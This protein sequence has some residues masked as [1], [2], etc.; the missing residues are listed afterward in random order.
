MPAQH[1]NVDQSDP[2]SRIHTE[3][4][5]RL[6]EY[7]TAAALGRA[8]ESLYPDIAAHLA[9]CAACRAEI[10]ELLDLTLYVYDGKLAPSPS[11]PQAN[12]T[13]LPKPNLWPDPARLWVVDQRG[14]LMISL[15]QPLLVDV[16]SSLAG[17]P[18]G[19]LL[20]RYI[21]DPGSVEDLEVTIE[22]FAEDTTRR[23]GRVQIVVDVPSRGPLDQIGSRVILRAD[24]HEWAGETDESGYVDFAPVPLN[25]V[26]QLRVE[27]APLRS[28]EC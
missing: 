12:L 7:A 14:R 15:S 18:R 26:P 5:D 28:Y 27:I 24:D 10:D 3:I 23:Q 11:Y 17:A 4:L 21:Q 2:M 16:A 22:V 1:Y 20:Y 25:L 9:Q 13:F 19:R 6:P 8:P